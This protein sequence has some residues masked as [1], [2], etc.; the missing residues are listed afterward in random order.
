MRAFERLSSSV[1]LSEADNEYRNVVDTIA[2]CDQVE[3][4]VGATLRLRVTA[5]RRDV[6]IG[7]DIPETISRKHEPQIAVC[8]GHG[9]SL[10]LRDNAHTSE[11]AIAKRSC[12][13][14]TARCQ[15]IHDVSPADLGA[16]TSHAVTLISAIYSMIA[17]QNLVAG[18]PQQEG[19][20]IADPSE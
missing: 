10:W 20:G 6:G 4:P 11:V 18:S 12:D 17:R 5:E 3:Q 14:E 1:A 15:R 8:E 7:N 9:R 2:S 16:G 13:H 19:A